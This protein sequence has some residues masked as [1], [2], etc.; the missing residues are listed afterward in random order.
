LPEKDPRDHD[1]IP[2]DYPKRPTGRVPLWTVMIVFLGLLGLFVYLVWPVVT[3]FVVWL[4]LVMILVPFA[5]HDSR[6]I[7]LIA[8][9]SVA[10]VIYGVITLWEAFFPFVV[11]LFLA[12]L[13]DPAADRLDKLLH[14]LARHEHAEP[15][16]DKKGGRLRAVAALTVIIVA[17]GFVVGLAFLLVPTVRDDI[18]RLREFDFTSLVSRVERWLDGIAGGSP[19]LREAVHS[20]TARLQTAI[21][22]AIPDVA[23][24]LER[25]LASLGDLGNLILIPIFTFLL[26]RDVDRFKKRLT[27]LVPERHHERLKD[28]GEDVNRVFVGF[29]RSKL[30]TCAFIGVVTGVGLWLLGVPFFIPLAVISGILNFI[31]FLGPVVAGAVAVPMAF[32]TPD[33]APTMLLTLG[34][35]V[36]AF[37]ISGYL[38][39]PLVVGKKVGI[40]AVLLILSVL[41]GLQ[42]G[43]VW[44]FLAVPIAAVIKVIALQVERFYRRS[45]IYR[46]LGGTE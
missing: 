36:V 32:F 30:V 16:K 9:V 29:F 17:V 27:D 11:A 28:F 8:L 23:V 43:I 42:F 6:A 39:D 35:Y 24:L 2:T 12:F 3:P 37:T 38:L 46:G 10:G 25:L 41:V 34:L 20:L 14:R 21:S 26:L 33:P 1:L 40:G 13:L 18:A 4:A 31:P 19:E 45:P 7:S 15:P 5:Y 22:E 44:A